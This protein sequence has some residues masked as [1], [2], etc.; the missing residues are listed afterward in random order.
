MSK[1]PTSIPLPYDLPGARRSAGRRIVTGARAAKGRAG[2]MIHV[3][4]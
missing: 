2:A 1:C 3:E 4:R